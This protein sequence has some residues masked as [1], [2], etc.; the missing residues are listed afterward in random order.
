LPMNW[1]VR[2]RPEAADS[3][4]FFRQKPVPGSVFVRMAGVST[5][6]VPFACVGR[7]YAYIAGTRPDHRSLSP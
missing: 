2:S 1:A 3:D 7:A 6:A 4:L 5:L